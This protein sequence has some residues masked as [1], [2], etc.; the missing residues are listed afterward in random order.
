MHNELFKLYVRFRNLANSEQGQDLVECALLCSLI[1]LA[2]MAGLEPV[3]A[4]VNK[5]FTDVSTSLA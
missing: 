4:A 3:A 1:A 5:V 2:V